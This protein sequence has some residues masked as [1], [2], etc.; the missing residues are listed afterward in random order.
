MRTLLL[1][2][3]LVFPGIG[4][5]VSIYFGFD[6]KRFVA[7][8][9]EIDSQSDLERFKQI[10]KKQMYGALGQF[11][12]LIIPT[13]LFLYGFFS[14]TLFFRDVAYLIVPSLVILAA[15]LYFKTL[16]RRAQTLPIANPQLQPERDR[17]VEVWKHKPFPDW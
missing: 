11:V 17:V 14:R 9:P 8:T 5:L 12:I 13:L 10:V 16:E 3:M 15:G 1:T 7:T 6:L 4:L 2:L